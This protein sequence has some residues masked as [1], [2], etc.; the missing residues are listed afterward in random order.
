M[1]V[2]GARAWGEGEEGGLVQ[3]IQSFSWKNDKV[4]KMDGTGGGCTT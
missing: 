2:A 4:L 1:V 3:W